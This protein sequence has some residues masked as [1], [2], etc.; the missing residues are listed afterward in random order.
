M[1]NADINDKASIGARVG[2]FYNTDAI[3]LRCSSA[4]IADFTLT[5]PVRIGPLKLVPEYRFDYS[6][7][8][9]ILKERWLWQQHPKYIKPSCDS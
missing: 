9:S 7:R 8:E 5:A 1:D 2:Y 3:A 6:T 4:H